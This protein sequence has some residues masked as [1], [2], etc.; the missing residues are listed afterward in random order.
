[1]F[2]QLTLIQTQLDELTTFDRA[3]IV[4]AHHQ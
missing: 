3:E 2:G 1:M 4:A